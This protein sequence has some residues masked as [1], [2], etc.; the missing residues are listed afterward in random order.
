MP[1]LDGPPLRSA[2]AARSGAPAPHSRQAIFF[3]GHRELETPRFHG[4]D[5]APGIAIDGP[6]IIDEPT[7]TIV[8]YPRSRARVTEMHNYLLEIAET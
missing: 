5:L 3:A 6:A 1:A 7:T 2:A 8:V 4:E